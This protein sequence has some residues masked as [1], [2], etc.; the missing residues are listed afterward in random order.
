MIEILRGEK[1]GRTTEDWLDGRHSFSFGAYYDADRL[2]FGSLRV[3][4]EDRVAPGRGFGPHPHRDMEILTVPIA[5][6][7]AH[8]D[9]EGNESVLGVG[10][11][12]LMSAGRGIVHSEMNPSQDETLHLLQIWIV[13]D[14][15]GTAPSYA[16]FDLPEEG[17][18]LVPILSPDGRDS[19]LRVQ[20][21]A[22]VSRLSLAAGEAF[23]QSIAAGRNLWIQVVSGAMEIGPERLEAGDAAAYRREPS[24][25]VE[26]RTALQALIFDLA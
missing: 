1:R 9:S 14:R 12:Q 3:L 26:A 20:Q 23:E 25:R 10:R 2:G 5:G 7:V 11:V 6:R 15:K 13:P 17:G 18:P 22:F 24:F 4:N 21:D 8:R 19:T 16:E